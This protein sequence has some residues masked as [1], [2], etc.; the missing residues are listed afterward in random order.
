MPTPTEHK[1]KKRF[2]LIPVALLAITVAGLSALKAVEKYPTETKAV[3]SVDLTAPTAPVDQNKSLKSASKAFADR[4]EAA[5][6]SSVSH[7]QLSVDVMK[8]R[9]N[10]KAQQQR[11]YAQMIFSGM[12]SLA[13]IYVI[14]SKKYPDEVNKWGYS[15]LAFVMGYWL[16][17]L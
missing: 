3:A 9:E 16:K 13:A 17:S 4:A 8:E 14:L 2:I 10:F 6:P 7:F 1:F 5:S 12:V 11:W 15:T